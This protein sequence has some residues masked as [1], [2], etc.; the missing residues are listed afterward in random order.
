MRRRRQCVGDRVSAR[1]L[2]PLAGQKKYHKELHGT[3]EDGDSF[4]NDPKLELQYAKFRKAY[5]K[6]RAKDF[7]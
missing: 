4:R 1:C 3:I 5:W 7:E 6:E 2:W